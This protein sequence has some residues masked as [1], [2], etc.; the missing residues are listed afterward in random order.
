M[1]AIGIAA[2][3]MI[4]RRA[5]SPSSPAPAARPIGL[6]G[7]TA[8]CGQAKWPTVPLMP[9]SRWTETKSTLHR[10]PVHKTSDTPLFAD[11]AYQGPQ[12]HD[13]LETILPHLQTQI[14]KRSDQAKGFVVL[15][16]G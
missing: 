15:P 14:V 10:N 6:R 4:A 5:R 1:T 9:N 3:S 8:R 12:F 13:A 2:Q 7:L 16:R 11:A